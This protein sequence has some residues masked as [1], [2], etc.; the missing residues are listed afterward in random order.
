MAEYRFELI[1]ALRGQLPVVIGDGLCV[2]EFRSSHLDEQLLKDYSVSDLRQAIPSIPEHV[3]HASQSSYLEDIAESTDSI[4]LLFKKHGSAVGSVRLTQVKSKIRLGILVFNGNNRRNGIGS[5]MLQF[6][7]SQFFK[8][9]DSQ[10]SFSLIAEIEKG[11]AASENF[12]EKN[13][14]RF[15]CFKPCGGRIV[16]Y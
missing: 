13:G 6:V 14:F 9:C 2:T 1:R 3:T 11:N 8:N 16:E 15:V 7:K 12:F 5:M 4:N 10:T